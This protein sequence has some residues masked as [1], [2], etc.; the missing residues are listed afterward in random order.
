MIEAGVFGSGP[1]LDLVLDF[2]FHSATD[3]YWAG[4]VD[5]LVKDGMHQAYVSDTYIGHRL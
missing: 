4:A 3:A 1:S 5:Y 2:S